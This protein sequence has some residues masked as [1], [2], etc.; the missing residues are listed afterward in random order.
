VS[1]RG[2]PD[3]ELSGDAVR[4][5][6]YAAVTVAVGLLL[7]GCQTQAPQPEDP[8]A[9]LTR[10]AT[11]P[12]PRS[13]G[14]DYT[15]A[16]R[17]AMLGSD[18]VARCEATAKRSEPAT[19]VD[20]TEVEVEGTRASA[21]VAFEG[22][23]SAG[24]AVT[25]DLVLDADRWRVDGQRDLEVVDRAAYE[26]AF[27]AAVGEAA[28]EVLPAANVPCVQDRFAARTDD[29][30]ERM[31]AEGTVRSFVAEAIVDCVASG[32]DL[33]ALTFITQ[34]ALSKSG[35][36]SRH[37]AACL[38]GA[39]IAGM[40]GLTVEQVITTPEGQQQ[41]HDAMLAAAELQVC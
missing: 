39:S 23:D 31:N 22:G 9:V 35:K 18:D 13:C 11:Q 36:I 28:A 3:D 8:G 15:A 32:S 6:A 19:S 40:D 37:E 17:E 2:G 14:Q 38:A 30:I 12:D 33:F 5:R 21:R 7:A 4:G 41:W 1:G 16:G 20:V 27:Q 26:V 10:L 25:V 24:T 34:H 29:E